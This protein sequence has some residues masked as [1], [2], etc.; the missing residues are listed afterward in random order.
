VLFRS[1]TKPIALNTLK[2]VIGKWLPAVA[3]ASTAPATPPAPPLAGAKAIDPRRAAELVAEILPLLA[4][5]KFDAI[6]RF[7]ALQEALDDTDA[8]AD[9]QAAGR[10][11]AEFRFDLARERLL[12]LATARGWDLPAS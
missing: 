1:L 8:A 6:A 7:R 5:N 4:Q 10:F 12:A 11:L 2:V 3:G 9:I